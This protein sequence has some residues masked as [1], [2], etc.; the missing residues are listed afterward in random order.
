MIITRDDTIPSAM[1]KTLRGLLH[2]LPDP[3]P[4]TWLEEQIQDLKETVANANFYLTYTL[5]GQKFG[6]EGVTVG[7]TTGDV[8]LA[9]LK[10]HQATWPEVARIYLI[11]ELLADQG[12]AYLGGVKKITEVA[13]SK[14]LITF[15]KY[16][17]FLPYAGTFIHTATDALRTNIAP[18]FDAIALNN[19][20]PEHYFNEQQWNQ[21]YLKAAFMQRPLLQIWGVENRANLTLSRIIS[22]YAHERWAASRDIDP[23]IWRPVAFAPV[24]AIKADMQHLLENGTEE[25]VHAAVLVAI[26]SNNEELME[27]VSS[28][29][30]ILER[31]ANKTL[32]WNNLKL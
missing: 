10:D 26:L 9:Y 22:D 23:H 4:F 24:D 8:C 25:E 14:E 16:V 28:R 31:I 30:E 19:P 2:S 15:L 6:D 1:L 18:V 3:T 27:M 32:N 17:F 21:M 5:I 29:K 20:Y 12:E 11:A 13:D 7:D